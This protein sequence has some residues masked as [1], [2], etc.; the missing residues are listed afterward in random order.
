M[1]QIQT[2]GFYTT[3]DFKQRDNDAR[4]YWMLENEDKGTL[5][6]K[7]LRL[8]QRGAKYSKSASGSLL[9]ELCHRTERGLYIYEKLSVA[10][11]RGF[12]TSRRISSTSATISK[13]KKSDLIQLLEQ[14]DEDQTFRL[15]DLP[16]ELRVEVYK[17]HLRSLS[18]IKGH[19]PTLPPL[20]RVSKLVQMESMPL[21]HEI[22]TFQLDLLY[23]GNG[24]DEID[25]F[26]APSNIARLRGIRKLKVDGN[27][28]CAWHSCPFTLQVRVDGT[29]AEMEVRD[30][31]DWYP[32]HNLAIDAAKA[33]LRKFYQKLVDR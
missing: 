28:Q 19:L 5:V 33:D 1:V 2:L 11:I 29:L 3:T 27:I 25:H 16:P 4:E 6:S 31:W 32:G 30:D 20:T 8:N 21:F 18:T 14:A 10:E 12:L 23:K 9:Q 26:F 15:L 22:C 24:R 7:R 17:H 13:M